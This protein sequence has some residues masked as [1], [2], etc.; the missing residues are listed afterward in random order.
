MTICVGI[1]N[2]LGGGIVALD[3]LKVLYKG[4]MPVVKGVKRNEYDVKGIVNVLKSLQKQA[5]TNGDSL[6]V[7]LE[8]SLIMPISGRIAVA[9]TAYGNGVFEGV[10]TSLG[11]PY[12]VVRPTEWQKVVLKGMDTSDTKKA[13]IIFCSRRFPAEDWTPSVRAKQEHTGLCDATCIAVYGQLISK[14]GLA[15]SWSEDF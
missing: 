5:K 12:Q 4:I 2:G 3:N 11:I 15:P 6:F 9:S 8:K 7:M 13:S 1:D 14:I 10:L